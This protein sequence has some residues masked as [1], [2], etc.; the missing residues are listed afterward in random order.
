[1][2]LTIF[3]VIFYS[4]IQEAIKLHELAPQYR[5]FYT[6]F[7]SFKISDQKS[8]IPPPMLATPTS[9]SS[10]SINNALGDDFQEEMEDGEEVI[11]SKQFIPF[12]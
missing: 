8:D 9:L 3:N 6:I 4:Y 12:T 2:I 7:E 11:I 1:M 10:K 5:Q